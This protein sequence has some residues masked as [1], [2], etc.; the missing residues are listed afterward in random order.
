MSNVFVVQSNPKHNLT[1][2]LKFGELQF[3]LPAQDLDLSPEELEDYIDSKLEKANRRDDWLLLAG[4]PIAIG[5]ACIA[6]DNGQQLRFLKWDGRLGDYIP[7]I[8]K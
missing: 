8:I 7:F 5:L 2:A 6:W 1:P 4:D 3:I